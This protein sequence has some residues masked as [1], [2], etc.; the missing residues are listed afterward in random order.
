MAEEFNGQFTDVFN[1]NEHRQEPF[2]DRSAHFIE[3]IVISK[4]ELNFS[5]D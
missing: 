1:R 2:L 5:K 4:D 3:E